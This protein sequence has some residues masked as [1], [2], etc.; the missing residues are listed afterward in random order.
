MAL[1][2]RQGE[3][4][5]T[6]SA[7]CLHW[8]VADAPRESHQPSG[9]GFLVMRKDQKAILAVA[10]GAGSG[11]LARDAT[12]RCLQALSECRTLDFHQVFD[13]CHRRLQ[14]TRGAAL[15][16]VIVDVAQMM[17][18]WA[19]L[20]DIDGLILSGPDERGPTVSMIQRPGTLGHTNPGV[21]P[22]R[23]PLG[24]GQ[25]VCLTTDGVSRTYRDAPPLAAA[26]ADLAPLLLETFGRD[27]DD[28]TV[29]VLMIGEGP[30]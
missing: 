21:S 20:G 9:D 1:S 25:L 23:H 22:Q 28:R 30:P 19:A 5:V 12:N 6:G 11:R 16:L 24:S 3:V 17:L 2:V 27:G 15:A 8:A 13:L 29:A 10:D 7:N 18:E 4:T 14:G 26:P